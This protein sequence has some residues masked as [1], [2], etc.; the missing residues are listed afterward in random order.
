MA[1]VG[2]HTKSGFSANTQTNPK[3]NCSAIF[4][5]SGSE[6]DTVNKKDEVV[7]EVEVKKVGVRN[8]NGDSKM[9]WARAR[10]A[11]EEK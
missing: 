8:T 1:E 11:K 10:S 7:E 6:C 2:E 9:K 4:T 3:A 5:I